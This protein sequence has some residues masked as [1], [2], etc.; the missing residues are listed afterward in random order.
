MQQ[1]AGDC[2]NNERIGILKACFNERVFGLDGNLERRRC[3]NNIPAFHLK[4]SLKGIENERKALAISGHVDFKLNLDIRR[5]FSSSA[6]LEKLHNGI[7]S[8]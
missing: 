2:P 4:N 5:L 7:V 3:F 6:M 1:L 8:D